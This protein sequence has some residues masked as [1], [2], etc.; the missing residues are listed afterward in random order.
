M[1]TFVAS[2]FV[3]YLHA[4][5]LPDTQLSKVGKTEKSEPAVFGRKSRNQ[6]GYEDVRWHGVPASGDCPRGSGGA[7]RAERRREAIAQGAEGRRL[8]KGQKGG[9]RR[10]ISSPV[11]LKQR[12]KKLKSI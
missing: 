11:W 1:L 6:R 10:N 12:G 5:T 3:I 2:S 8:P 4:H 7:N 9:D